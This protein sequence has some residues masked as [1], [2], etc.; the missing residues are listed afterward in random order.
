MY[1]DVCIQSVL[2]SDDWWRRD[3]SATLCRGSLIFAFSPHI[4]QV[5]YTFEPIGRTNPT[6]HHKA[7]VR[8]SPLRVDQLLQKATLPVAA[9]TLHDGEVWA[10][11]RAKK[12]PCLVIGEVGLPVEKNL[13]LGKP[14]H[15]TAPTILVAPY[16]G[17]DR[18]GLRSGY[19]PEF[20]ERVRHLE[21]PQF[22][23]DRLPF[24]G[25]TEESILRLDH[26]QPVGAHHQSYKL[27][28]FKLCEVGVEVIDQMLTW[29]LSGGVE[30]DCWVAQYR[31]EIEK[32]FR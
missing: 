30:P 6:Q 32:N 29:L 28:G 21:Y 22:M 18:N 16:Y 5:P 19:R 17:V 7:E 11:Y 20:V 24:D 8:V 31:E 23:W 2:A 27:S 12:R 4:D 13:T 25:A 9:M 14:N 3:T 10:A 15:A 26:L 1:P